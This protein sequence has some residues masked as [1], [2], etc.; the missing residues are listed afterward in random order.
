[1]SATETERI[2]H[3]YDRRA[4]TYDRSIGLTERYLLGSFRQQF[5]ALLRGDTLEAGIGSGLNLPFYSS[6][7]ARAV[8]VDLSAEMLASARQRADHLGLAIELM[9]ADVEALPFADATFDTVAI[10]LTLC[11][12][13]QPKAALRELARVCRPGGQIVFL[14]HVLSPI[15]P[16]AAAERLLSPL[17]ERALGCHLDRATIDVAREMGFEM[18]AEQQRLFGVFRLAVAKPPRMKPGIPG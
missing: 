14:E 3:I 9:Q 4:A 5:G 18:A 12:T 6:A 17:Q 10:S 16:L 7:V 15:W 8:G 11:T 2:R 13:P 1:M